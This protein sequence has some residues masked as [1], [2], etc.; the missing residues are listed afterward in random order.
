MAKNKKVGKNRKEKRDETKEKFEFFLEVK[1]LSKDVSSPEYILESDVGLDLRAN[2]N[3]SL[4]PM[5]QKIVKTGLIIKVPKG[6]VGLIRDRAGIVGKMNIHTVAGT[7]D[8]DYRGEV[9]IFL[10]NF[11]EEEAH[12]EKGMRIAQMIFVP[13]TRVG[14]KVVKSLSETKRG[15][16]G[17]GS[18]GIR[19][20]VKALL[21]LDKE[22]NKENISNI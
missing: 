1:K 6:H 13:V 7:F 5:E 16:K 17:F 11:G 3:I 2:E 20:K 15:S 12:I 10:V 14:V 18:T 4:M 9:S 8:P 22:I 21:E 19:E